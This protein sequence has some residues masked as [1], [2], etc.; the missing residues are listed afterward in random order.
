MFHLLVEPST[1]Y[2]PDLLVILSRHSVA[3]LGVLVQKVVKLTRIVEVMLLKVLC[4][5]S[6]LIGHLVVKSLVKEVCST[7]SPHWLS[8]GKVCE[9]RV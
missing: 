7:L 8:F 3:K 4:F 2:F 6:N 9:E 1:H 5:V